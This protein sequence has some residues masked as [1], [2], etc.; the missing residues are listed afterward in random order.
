MGLCS[1][2]A[3]RDAHQ[4]KGKSYCAVM[5]TDDGHDHIMQKVEGCRA[6]TKR[7]IG[8]GRKPHAIRERLE[9]AFVYCRSIS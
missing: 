1:L 8:I 2:D 6:Y 4:F 5:A 7:Y 3:T 9:V